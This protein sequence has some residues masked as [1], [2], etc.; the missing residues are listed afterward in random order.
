MDSLGISGVAAITIICLLIGLWI[1]TSALDDRWIPCIVGTVGLALGPVGWK[2]MPGFP[3]DNLV[4]ALAVGIVS[5][6]AA[7]GM[8]Q[9]YKQLTRPPDAQSADAEDMEGP[10]NDD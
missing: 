7:T 8:H 5:G 2:L 9:I 6:L 10:Y 3:A 1:K 4:T